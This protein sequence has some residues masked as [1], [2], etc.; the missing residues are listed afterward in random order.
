MYNFV[1][2]FQDNKVAVLQNSLLS[3]GVSLMYNFEGCLGVEIVHFQGLLLEANDDLFFHYSLREFTLSGRFT[4]KPNCPLAVFLL[5]VDVNH[6]TKFAGNRRLKVW[7]HIS[8]L[9]VFQYQDLL[10]FF[11]EIFTIYI[12]CLKCKSIYAHIYLYAYIYI[13]NSNKYC[14]LLKHTYINIYI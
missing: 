6:E 9:H 7:R 3:K 13:Y 10:V 11:K 12:L 8:S 1:D 4:L 2:Y 14:F 5:T